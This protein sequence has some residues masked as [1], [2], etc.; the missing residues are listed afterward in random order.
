MFWLVELDD[1]LGF[2][3]FVDP[4]INTLKLNKL[5]PNL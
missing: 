5:I 2:D 3:Q 1:N 4:P